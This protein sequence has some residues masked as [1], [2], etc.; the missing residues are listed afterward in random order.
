[1]PEVSQFCP[2]CGLAV[3]SGPPSEPAIPGVR[4]V[5]RD[6]LL[7]AIAYVALLPAIVFLAVPG[8]RTAR[9][10]RFH[11]WQSVLLAGATVLIGFA[12]RAAFAVLLLFPMVGFLVAWLLSGVVGLAIVLLWVAIMVK[13]GLGDAFEVALIGRWAARLANRD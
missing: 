11:A 7:G 4:P 12:T 5:S 8:F 3:G 1:M 6:A 10:I 13:A 9:F 2:G